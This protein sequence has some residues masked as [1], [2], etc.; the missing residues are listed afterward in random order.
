MKKSDKKANILCLIAIVLALLPNAFLWYANTFHFSSPIMNFVETK[1]IIVF[2]LISALIILYVK[3]K[4]PTNKLGIILFAIVA[5]I[6][7]FILTVFIL[8]LLIYILA[9]ILFGGF[10]Y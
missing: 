7:I 2:A 10:K 9:Y 6:I 3:I 5:I 4:F 8:F 1:L